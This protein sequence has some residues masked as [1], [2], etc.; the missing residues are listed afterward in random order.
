MA[1]GYTKSRPFAGAVDELRFWNRSLSA[2]FIASNMHRSFDSLS[3]AAL[4]GMQASGLVAHYSFDEGSGST[5]STPLHPTPG[6]MGVGRPEEAPG[7]IPS[8]FPLVGSDQTVVGAYGRSIEITLHGAVPAAEDVSSATFVITELPTSGTLAAKATLDAASPTV[9]APAD[10][11][12]SLPPTADL[13]TYTPSASFVGTSTFTFSLATASR[14]SSAPVHVNAITSGDSRPVAGRAGSVHFGGDSA[15]P[16]IET[17]DWLISPNFAMETWLRT[18]SPSN[19][20]IIS[21]HSTEAKNLFILGFYEQ[22]IDVRLNSHEMQFF[23]DGMSNFQD[24]IL[25]KTW[26]L[27]VSCAL[28]AVPADTTICSVY[29]DGRELTDSPRV[30]EHDGHSVMETRR[31]TL[32]WSIG[33]EF[34]GGPKVSDVFN[35]DLDDVRIWNR[36]ISGDEV[37]AN[38]HGLQPDADRSGLLLDLHFDEDL[39]SRNV[40]E[41]ERLRR[42]KLEAIAFDKS[43]DIHCSDSRLQSDYVATVRNEPP[44]A[45]DA[46]LGTKTNGLLVPSLLPSSLPSPL[47]LFVEAGTTSTFS[48][49]AADAD[50]DDQLSASLTPATSQNPHPPGLR[51]ISATA[52]EYDAPASTTATAT[53][54]TSFSYF[55]SDTLKESVVGTAVIRVL[56]SGPSVVSFTAV[57]GVVPNNALSADDR[58]VLSF[59]EPTNQPAHLMVSF[60]PPDVVEIVEGSATWTSSYEYEFKIQHSN[61]SAAV[62]GE[63]LINKLTLAVLE[64]TDENSLLLNSAKTSYFS[65]ARSPPLDG[66]WTTLPPPGVS[67]IML[68]IGGAILAFVVS[69]GAFIVTTERGKRIKREAQL[70]AS[71]ETTR[72]E[73]NQQRISLTEDISALQNEVSSRRLQHAHQA[74]ELEMMKKAVDDLSNEER[75]ENELKEVLIPSSEVLTNRVIGKGGF[76]VVHLADFKGQKVAVKTLLEINDESL[77]RFRFECFLMKNLRHPNVVRLVGVVWELN[78]LACCLEYVENETL[79]F[80]LRK[81]C[82]KP[83]NGGEDSAPST[84]AYN[85]FRTK[86]LYDESLYASKDPSNIEKV[87][88]M[89]DMFAEECDDAGEAS[90]CGW[91]FIKNPVAPNEP[92]EDGLVCFTRH[93]DQDPSSRIGGIASQ[94]S[95]F[96]SIISAPPSWEECFARCEINATPEQVFQCHTMQANHGFGEAES[97]LNLGAFQTLEES[98]MGRTEYCTVDI[99]KQIGSAAGRASREL[100]YRGVY[101]ALDG[102]RRGECGGFLDAVESDNDDIKESGNGAMAFL[103]SLGGRGELV[104]MNIR[105]GLLVVPKVGTDGAISVVYR[106]TALDARTPVKSINEIRKKAIQ[107]ESIELT[108]GTL[109]SL[110]RCTE[111]LLR[112]FVVSYQRSHLTWKGELARLALHCA[113]GVQYLHNERYFSSEKGEWQECIIHRDL[114]PENMLVTNDW[115][116]KLTDFGEARA[117]DLNSTMTSVGTPIFV[118]PEVMTGNNYDAKCDSYSFGVCLFA[119][120]RLEP[121]IT[122]AFLESLRKHMKR[123]TRKGVGIAILN[124]RMINAG[125]RPVIPLAFKRSYPKLS[126]LIQNCWSN[127]PDERPDFEAIA[128]L[129]GEDICEEVKRNK[130]PEIFVLSEEADEIYIKAEHDDGVVDEGDELNTERGTGYV[131][132]EAHQT[133]MAAVHE[134]LRVAKA[135][136]KLLEEKKKRGC[137]ETE[138]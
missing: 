71:H 5:V 4:R 92:L 35:G 114:K 137:G 112:G 82:G 101:K 41:P 90:T 134:E 25:G 126:K 118:A 6:H 72:R 79:E 70:L 42:C 125:W 93:V 29:M 76:G 123:A 110:K 26:H 1:D 78:M 86:E 130:E 98:T 128:R 65:T 58:I 129:L 23:S 33:Q 120:I 28:Q 63:T 24:F 105:H 99:F 46:G 12:F 40:G 89:I 21:H 3:P 97:K 113:Q 37:R 9:L 55:T 87:K 11:P 39:A 66:S 107:R 74:E 84:R 138:Q 53:A 22:S 75:R 108:Y 14:G 2:S 69:V 17:T 45:G 31:D 122:G 7:W 38:L 85:G 73:Y 59:D 36:T 49:N 43:M 91:M 104:R 8:P 127:E 64:G 124:N 119:M 27:A 57:S 20:A 50:A 54:T 10:L 48:L 18:A 115:T 51:M 88:S 131:R 109:L 61:H 116:L 60:D 77:R 95:A 102:E 106:A 30:F 52:C 16:Y 136:L 100:R 68:A 81:T 121:T 83:A 111:R 96:S 15:G 32:P 13:V 56:Q 135:Q 47:H 19:Q 62:V 94:Q 80:W 34:D 67:A 103:A 132:V 117:T 44:Q 133:L